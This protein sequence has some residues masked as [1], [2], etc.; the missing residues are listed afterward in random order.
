MY[1][2]RCWRQYFLCRCSKVDF[3]YRCLPM[4][5]IV[6]CKCLQMPMFESWCQTRM[7]VD[8]RHGWKFITLCQCWPMSTTTGIRTSCQLMFSLWAPKVQRLKITQSHKWHLDTN[9]ANDSN[10]AMTQLTFWL[11]K[12]FLCSSSCD[13][14]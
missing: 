12:L 11:R 9:D 6:R 10:D 5:T 2:N 13:L 8:F 3:G 1:G 14:S 4:L 7:K